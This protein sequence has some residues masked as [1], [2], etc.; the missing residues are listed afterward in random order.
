[1]FT[2]IWGVR[3]WMCS[4]VG[5]WGQLKQ[6]TIYYWIGCR[7]IFH[8]P[9][10]KNIKYMSAIKMFV[11]KSNASIQIGWKSICSY[12]GK[13]SIFVFDIDF[14]CIR[15]FRRIWLYVRLNH[16]RRTQCLVYRFIVNIWHKYLETINQMRFI[17]FIT[18][19]QPSM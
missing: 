9:N 2:I 6:Q 8:E 14:A 3:T 1:M 7:T 17:R 11:L 10:N 15:I 19:T 18:Y 13:E 5:H 16:S 12:F 4:P